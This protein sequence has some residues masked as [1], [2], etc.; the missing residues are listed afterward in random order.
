MVYGLSPAGA[1]TGSSS[2]YGM[3]T[4]TRVAKANMIKA[5]M[6]TVSILF[7]SVG[8]RLQRADQRRTDAL[9]PAPQHRGKEV[10]RKNDRPERHQRAADASGREIRERHSERVDERS[11][12]V[13]H[14][15]PLQQA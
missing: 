12:G 15:Q 10:V 4:R 9:R 14:G 3:T 11:G 13:E 2:R 6:T 5:P 1:V 7:M 8:A